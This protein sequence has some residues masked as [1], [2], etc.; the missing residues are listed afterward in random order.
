MIIFPLFLIRRE[1]N[2]QTE[3]ERKRKR[4]REH[5]REIGVFNKD[6]HDTFVQQK[7]MQVKFSLYTC[8]FV[9]QK[10]KM[11]ILRRKRNGEIPFCSTL[12]PYDEENS[13]GKPELLHAE[14]GRFH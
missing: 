11:L 8:D 6:D 7:G 13:V 4:K 9:Y 2:R 12:H 3:T 1:T 14:Y 10:G 5:V